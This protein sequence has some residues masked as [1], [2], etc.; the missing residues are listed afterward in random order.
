MPTGPK[1][2]KEARLKLEQSDCN[3]AL[4][5]KNMKNL[6]YRSAKT[7]VRKS[8]IHGQGLFAKEPI[9]EGEIVAVKPNRT[10]A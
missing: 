5:D 6:T 3:L 7:E 4:K 9:A 2:T 8:P 1:E 10:S